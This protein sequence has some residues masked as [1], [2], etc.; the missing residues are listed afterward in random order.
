[1]FLLKNDPPPKQN[2]KLYRI[3]VPGLFNF[4]VEIAYCIPCFW[5]DA[6]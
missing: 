5:P 4:Y 1:M 6:K 2:Q 3:Q